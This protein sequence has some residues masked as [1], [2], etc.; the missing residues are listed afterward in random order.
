MKTLRFILLLAMVGALVLSACEPQ[1]VEV[2]VVVEKPVEVEKEVEVTRI[3]EGAAEVVEVTRV[4]EVDKDPRY[5]GVYKMAVA[6]SAPTLDTMTSMAAATC[7]PMQNVME[8]LVAYNE[9]YLIVPM[10]AESWE[11]S[12]DGLTFTFK[13]RQGVKFHNGTEMTSEDVVASVERYMNVGP[14]KGQFS[15]LESWEALDDYTVAFHLSEPSGSFLDALAYPVGDLVIMPKEV[16]EGK[17]AGDLK[18]EELIGTGPYMLA[19]WQPGE[20][21]RMVRFEDYQPLEGG[22]SGLAGGKITFFDEVQH[23]YVP[24]AGARVAGVET[25][26]YDWAEGIPETEYERLKSADCVVPYIKNAAWAR[27]ILFNHA[28]F[29]TSDVNFRQAVLAVLD[30]NEVSMAISGGVKQFY[31]LNSSMF[32]PEGPWYIED[33]VAEQL[34]NANDVER[35]KELL[36]ASGYNGEEIIMVTNRDYDYMYKLILAVAD[37]LEKKLGLNVSV[38]VLDWPGQRA[39]WEEQE[40][41]HM[42]TT[43]YLSQVIFNPDALASFWHC[44]SASSERGFYCNEEMDA[45]FEAASKALTFEERYEAFKEVQRLYYED[46]P[47]IKIGDFFNLEIMRC[48]LKGHMNWYR[49]NVPWGMWRE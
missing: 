2:T 34:Y 45:A 12:D 1:T 43:G 33:P 35:A 24:E 3:V 11:I 36:A 41:W 22:T 21:I 47:N 49:A 15:L 8:T 38:E 26:E 14:R 13:L 23:I 27:M 19:E 39:K 9:G 25:G 10:L 18:T 46:L 20:I 17:G 28:N 44:D 32:V 30:M 5:G 6:A 31:R 48:D 40:T 4:I 7:Y 37:Q 29:P 42:S 16:I